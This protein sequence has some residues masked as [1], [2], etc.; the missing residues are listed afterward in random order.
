MEHCYVSISTL[1]PA[2]QDST[3]AIQPTVSAFHYPATRPITG[4]SLQLAHILAATGDVAGEP[5]LCHECVDF[6]VVVALVETEI[7]R[8]CSR[9]SW[10]LEGNAVEGFTREPEVVDVRAGDGEPKGN[11]ARLR[12]HASLG[13]ALGSVGWIA[14][15]FF[16]HPAAPSTSPHPS[17]A[18]PSRCRRTHRSRIVLGSTPPRTRQPRSIRQIVD[19]PMSSNRFAYHSARSTGSQYEAQRELRSLH[20][21]PARAV[22]GI[23]ADAPASPAAA[24][25]SRST[26]RLEFS[27]RRLSLRVPCRAGARL[28]R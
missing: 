27:S 20:R 24:V 23:Q 9:R 14:A 18:T 16:P 7:L 4:A 19:A 26:A 11:A 8:L 3:E 1:L 25:R 12:Q 28:T 6:S 2:N 22:G 17:T 15:A 21:D 5:K 10:T 13:P